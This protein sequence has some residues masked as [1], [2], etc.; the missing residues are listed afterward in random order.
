MDNGFGYA[1]AVIRG[2]FS[3]SFIRAAAYSLGYYVYE[4]VLWRKSIRLSGKARIHATASIR[5]A[6]NIFVGHNSHINHN[7]CIWAGTQS[8]IILGDNLLMGPGVKIFSGNH[9]MRLECPMAFQERAEADV[10]I[11]NDV[12][13]GAGSIIVSGV[14]IGDGTVVAAGSVVTKNLPSYAIAGGVPA[15]VI[16]DRV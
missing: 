11:G 12:W 9:G 8:K 1:K 14:R 16:R 4:H 5:N 10:I 6:G 13:L 7:C 15:K 3:F 2:I